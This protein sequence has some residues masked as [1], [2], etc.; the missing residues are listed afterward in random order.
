MIIA[1]IIINKPVILFIHH[2]LRKRM[3]FL[4]IETKPTKLAHQ[5]KASQKNIA[6]R[7]RPQ[8]E[9]QQ[10][11]E[12]CDILR[13]GGGIGNNIFVSVLIT[14]RI[15]AGGFFYFLIIFSNFSGSCR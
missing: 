10:L 12:V 3:R 4:N 6:R 13:R 15:P 5:N 9:Q 8:T 1:K 14:K 2:R 7:S 11:G